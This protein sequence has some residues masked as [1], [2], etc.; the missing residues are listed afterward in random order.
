MMGG[1]E[2]EGAEQGRARVTESWGGGNSEERVGESLR[3][4]IILPS[5]SSRAVAV[6]F[7]DKLAL[8]AG[9]EKDA[10]ESADTVGC[11][12]LRVE[13]LSESDPA[14]ADCN[15]ATLFWIHGYRV[16]T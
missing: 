14:L 13:H 11:C 4:F 9:N 10:D 6:Y 3:R 16:T 8:R 7:I 5:P 1:R 2:V 12:S 15:M